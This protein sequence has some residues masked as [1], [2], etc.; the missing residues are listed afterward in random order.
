MLGTVGGPEDRCLWAGLPFTSP[1]C[2]LLREFWL[3]VHASPCPPHFGLGLSVPRSHAGALLLSP[4]L[5]SDTRGF[6]FW[7]SCLRSV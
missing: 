2:S 7:L 3:R 5:Q 6:E 1:P 4:V